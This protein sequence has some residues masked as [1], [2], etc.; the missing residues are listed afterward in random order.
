[1]L[2]WQLSLSFRLFS[3]TPLFSRPKVWFRIM[4]DPGS[5]PIQFLLD[6]ALLVIAIKSK[7][8]AIAAP[9][10]TR[11]RSDGLKTRERL[12]FRDTEI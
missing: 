1:M 3:R 5:N 2:F 7:I 10:K 9:G 11:G 8:W 6:P 4:S 12:G